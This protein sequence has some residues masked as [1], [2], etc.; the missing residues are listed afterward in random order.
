MQHSPVDTSCDS[1]PH[2][3]MISRCLF[4]AG[5]ST[6]VASLT[7][8]T[9]LATAVDFTV[10][11]LDGQ[12][13]QLF[14]Y[15]DAGKHVCIDFFAHWCSNCATSAS[16][17]TEAFHAFG[18]NEGD[19]IFLGIELEGSQAQVEAFETSHA[20]DNPPPVASGAD[21]GGAA[22]HASY[23]PSSFPTGILIAP[24]RDIVAQY[25]SLFSS[26]SIQDALENAGI[27]T[28]ECGVSSMDETDLEPVLLYP[29]PSSTF[30]TVE[31]S[32]GTEL[33]LANAAGKVINTL[34]TLHQRTIVSTESLAPGIYMLRAKNAE[35]FWVRQV[36]VQR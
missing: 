10:T 36:V 23:G 8:Q 4:V 13:H 9:S 22:V 16:N 20:G 26:A 19:V 34:S 30:V 27:E 14:E 2:H 29:N 33:E 6:S 11:D 3:A 21:G 1:K 18:C 25:I 32:P 5:L 17:F 28:M 7:A 35:H 12:Q 15:L 24:N 31:C